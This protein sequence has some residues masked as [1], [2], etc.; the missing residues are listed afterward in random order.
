MK[1]LIIINDKVLNRER[2]KLY[3][4]LNESLQNIHGGHEK[5]STIFSV[6]K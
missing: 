5:N 4:H 6:K 3:S 2:S 1:S